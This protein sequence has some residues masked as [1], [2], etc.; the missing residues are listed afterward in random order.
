MN[1][2][3]EVTIGNKELYRC[4]HREKGKG[5]RTP[6]KHLNCSVVFNKQ[7]DKVLF[8]NQ[9]EGGHYCRLPAGSHRELD[10]GNGETD[11]M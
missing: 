3:S 4:L 1:H 7:K 2:L 5:E 8:R 11:E 10:Y 6:L 9:G